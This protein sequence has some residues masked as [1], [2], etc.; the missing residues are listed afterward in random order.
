MT[1]EARSTY[2]ATDS[3][4]SNESWTIVFR[5]VVKCQ[6]IEKD[7]N[8]FSACRSL[9]LRALTT[10]NTLACEHLSH[11]NKLMVLLEALDELSL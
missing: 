4:S 3:Q 11:A 6:E 7:H 2:V 10:G 1:H 5:R 8:L 9:S